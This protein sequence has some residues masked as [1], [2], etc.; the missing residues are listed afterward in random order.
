MI[1]CRNAERLLDI[2]KLQEGGKPCYSC[3]S[4]VENNSQRYAVKLNEIY[5]MNRYNCKLSWNQ[6]ENP[7]TYLITDDRI[8]NEVEITLAKSFV[9]R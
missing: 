8:N 6:V 7:E 3:F 4:A 2:S 5:N 1:S 9:S